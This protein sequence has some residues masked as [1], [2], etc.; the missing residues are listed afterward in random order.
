[1]SDI[2]MSDVFDLPVEASEDFDDM[3]VEV[4]ISLDLVDKYAEA[5]VHAINNH[6]DLVKKVAEL[7]L[8]LDDR[9]CYIAEADMKNEELKLKLD[10]IEELVVDARRYGAGANCWVSFRNKIDSILKESE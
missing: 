10:A 1:M 5:A 7:E 9:D 3:E 2:K 4:S 8:S 6:D